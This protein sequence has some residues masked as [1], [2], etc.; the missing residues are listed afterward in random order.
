MTLHVHVETS[1]KTLLDEV[2]SSGGWFRAKKTR[3]IWVKAVDEDQVVESLEG[4][5]PVKRG[6]CL[7][8]SERG[9]LWPQSCP[10]IEEKY[11]PTDQVDQDGWRKYAPRLDAD[12]VLAAQVDHEFKIN[13]PWGLLRGKAG[14][15]VV[16]NFADANTA[17]P[18]DV[19][20]VDQQ[21]FIATYERIGMP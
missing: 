14:D 6:D 21:L 19:W 2:N 10:A 4:T 12:G 17:Y 13:G 9:E 3:P 7:C 20:L 18:D 15:F 1:N 11:N 16:K 5:Q 8:R